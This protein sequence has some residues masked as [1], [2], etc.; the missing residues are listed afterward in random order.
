MDYLTP[1][2]LLT[3]ELNWEDL[4]LS[5]SVKNDIDEILMWLK[6]EKNIKEDTHLNKWLKPGY[7]ALFYGPSGTGKTLTA[8]IIGKSVNK[9]V[10]K[11][12]L[13]MVFSKYIGET[14]KNLAEVFDQAENNKWI[15]FFDEADALFGKRTKAPSPNDRHANKEIAY[16]LQRIEDF[17]GLIIIA[18]NLKSHIDEAFSR[19]FQLLVPFK[20]PNKEERYMLWKRIFSKEYSLDE[21]FIRQS[22]ENYELTGGALINVLHRALLHSQ[23]DSKPKISKEA[24]IYAI[25]K[26]FEKECK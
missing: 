10:Y 16:I 21:E 4:V 24:V 20:M 3:T 15:L 7:R 2:R 18:S 23:Q 22:S 14:E 25:R 9:P 19:R 17:S 13:S 11:I 26:E 8:S 6:L 1:A 12:D 5:K